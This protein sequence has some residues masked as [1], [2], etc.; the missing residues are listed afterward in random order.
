MKSF[1]LVEDNF[2]SKKYCKYIIDEYKNKTNVEIKH[3]GYKGFYINPNDKIFNEI[4]LK[5]LESIKKYVKLYPEINLTKD[6]WALTELT[7]KHFEPGNHFADWHS[8]VGKNCNT[9]I[10]NMMIYLSEHNCGTQFFNKKVI[11]S[12]IGR[13]TIFPSYFTHTHRGQICP[14]NK[15][16]YILGGY[17]NFIDI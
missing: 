11:K 7:F 10:L 13:I 16:R 14:D 3:T 12:R 6:K 17:Y 5:I 1:I 9:R 15:D 4:Q 2:L 8:E